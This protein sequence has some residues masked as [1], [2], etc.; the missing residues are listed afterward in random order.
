MDLFWL[1]CCLTHEF[2]HFFDLT[3]DPFTSTITDQ[4]LF[5]I[6]TNQPLRVIEWT[7]PQ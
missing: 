3:D 4:R 7:P 2:S 5:N 1:S 6:L